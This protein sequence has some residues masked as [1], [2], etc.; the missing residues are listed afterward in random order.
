MNKASLSTTT[1]W[2]TAEQFA[3]KQTGD[4]VTQHG[5]RMK[6]AALC[7]LDIVNH[8]TGLNIE[9]LSEYQHEKEVLV[10]PYTAFSITVVRRVADNYTEI[11]LRE[12]EVAAVDDDDEDNDDDGLEVAFKFL[13]PLSDRS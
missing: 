8:R 11:Y 4:R 7:S 10:G 12:C 6:V 1:G 9:S 5:E 13:T 3:T 2:T